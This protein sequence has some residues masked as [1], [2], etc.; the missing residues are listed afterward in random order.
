MLKQQRRGHRVTVQT[1]WGAPNYLR[2]TEIARWD[3]CHQIWLTRQKFKCHKSGSIWLLWRVNS[4]KVTLSTDHNSGTISGAFSVAARSRT[5][6]GTQLS[7]QM[8]LWLQS[9]MKCQMSIS[10]SL[11]HHLIMGLTPPASQIPSCVGSHHALYTLLQKLHLSSNWPVSLF[12][13]ICAP[14]VFFL[15]SPT[16]SALWTTLISSSYPVF[17]SLLFYYSI[18]C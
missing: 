1:L 16:L 12:Y 10:S 18:L 14:G 5:G 2:G 6:T 3:H 4:L 15:L 17:S 13:K 8:K 11:C 7:P 9:S